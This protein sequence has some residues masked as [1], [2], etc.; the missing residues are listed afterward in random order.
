[1]KCFHNKG[2]YYR[3]TELNQLLCVDF[4]PV[5]KI[6][7]VSVTDGVLNSLTNND[8]QISR[9]LF[10]EKFDLAANQLKAL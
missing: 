1:M 10:D 4:F 2:N 8:D 5:T 3:V 6:E 7:V 9:K